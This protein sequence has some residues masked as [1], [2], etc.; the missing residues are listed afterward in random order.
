MFLFPVFSIYPKTVPVAC[1]KF[2]YPRAD[3]VPCCELLNPLN[4]SYSLLWAPNPEHCSCLYVC[5][6]SACQLSYQ[7]IASCCC[8][9][10]FYRRL[11]DTPP[12]LP[13]LGTRGLHQIYTQ[14]WIY[15]SP[16]YYQSFFSW[17]FPG[18]IP[19]FVIGQQMFWNI[20]CPTD[21]PINEYNF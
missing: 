19:I 4:C 20:F 3:L 17:V 18:F 5:L 15:R 8:R 2:L 11:P 1:C 6:E 16:V 10:S 9:D 21:Q 13:S 12:P 14:T 7:K